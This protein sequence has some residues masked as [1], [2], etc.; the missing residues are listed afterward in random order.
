MILRSYYR[1]LLGITKPVLI[2]VE[3]TTWSYSKRKEVTYIR[4]RIL[5]PNGHCEYTM[6]HRFKKDYKY[7]LLDTS[8]FVNMDGFRSLSDTV[9]SMFAYDK[10]TNYKIIDFM[11]I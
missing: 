4:W 11:E 7:S 2:Q 8:C 3:K 10:D 5:Y 9:R 1:E 6:D